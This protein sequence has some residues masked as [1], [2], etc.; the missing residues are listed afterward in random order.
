MSFG[1]MVNILLGFWAMVFGISIG[2]G[3]RRQGITAHNLFSR[4]RLISF[5]LLAGSVCVAVVILHLPQ[6]PFLPL[7]W[8]ASGMLMAWM[9]LRSLLFW[10]GGLAIAMGWQVAHRQLLVTLFTC[11]V[12]V[13]VLTG[14]EQYLLTP[15]YPSLSQHIDSQGIVRQT[16]DSSCAPAALATVLHQ[17]QIDTSELEVAKLAGTS[18][19]G[20]S[21]PQLI[22]AAQRLGMDGLE[23][24]PSWET[25]QQINRPG[26]LSIWLM[27]GD[28]RFPHAVALL[29]MNR[30]TAVIAD[31]AEGRAF[32]VDRTA[33]EKMWRQEYVPIFRP[34]DLKLSPEAA[35]SYL[36]NLGYDFQDIAPTS[37]GTLY[38][39]APHWQ[40]ALRQFQADN[41]GLPKSGT[42][43]TATILA[44]TGAF[45]QQTPTLALADNLNRSAIDYHRQG[46]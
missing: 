34:H 3:L 5:L 19:I 43:D 14:I 28:R 37:L 42:L 38:H 11:G 9:V 22:A 24:Q 25:I 17:W 4:R 16:S 32:M 26:I 1:V 18:R 45:V 7:A 40:Q 20:T 29:K 23:L 27:D 35:Q 6:L 10:I 46:A 15:I 30:D 33:L 21:M 36:A 39:S 12:G 41:P 44:L 8:R 13:A 31:P 2:W